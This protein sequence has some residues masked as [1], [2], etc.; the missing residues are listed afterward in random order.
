MKRKKKYM[1]YRSH[2]KTCINPY[3][4]DVLD[5]RYVVELCPSCRFVGKLGLALGA[6]V[7]GVLVKLLK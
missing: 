3:C 4:N 1:A 5:R 7:A 2:L 6:L